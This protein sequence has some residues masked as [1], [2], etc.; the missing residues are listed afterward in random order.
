MPSYN[1]RAVRPALPID[2]YDY[3]DLDLETDEAY[4]RQTENLPPSRPTYRIAGAEGS[5]SQRPAQA[6]FGSPPAVRR[7]MPA[8]SRELSDGYTTGRRPNLP[9]MTAYTGRTN[10]LSAPGNW[11]FSSW[12]MAA[13]AVLG[14]LVVSYLVVSALVGGWQSWQDDQAYGWPRLTRLE[15]KVGHNETGPNAKTLLIAQNLKGQVCIIEIPGGDPTQTRVIVGPQLFGKGRDLIPIRLSTEDVNG[16]GQP[17]L[18]ATVQD[19]KLIYINEKGNFRPITEP[20]RAKL[21][22]EN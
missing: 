16:D 20:E 15:A 6:T 17:D 19:Q 4:N 10:P 14:V 22:V 21:R 5:Q 1:N 2:D 3:D 8:P 13:G 18:I 7:P 9:P 12:L 11:K